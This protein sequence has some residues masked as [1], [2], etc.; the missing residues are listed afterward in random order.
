MTIDTTTPAS[1]E[2]IEETLKDLKHEFHSLKISENEND[3][4]GNGSFGNVYSAYWGRTQVAVKSVKE[5]AKRDLILVEASIM[6]R[7]RHPNI[8]EFWGIYEP[9]PTEIYLVMEKLECSMDVKLKE[10]RQL[11]DKKRKEAEFNTLQDRIKW[12]ADIALAFVYL[13]GQDPK[14]VH[15]D[16][17]PNNVLIGINNIAKVADFGISRNQRIDPS[18][19][20]PTMVPKC[21]NF[22]YKPPEAYLKNFSSQTSYDVYSYAMTIYEMLFLLRP[23]E[24]AIYCDDRNLK[25]WTVGGIRPPLDKVILGKEEDDRFKN[26]IKKCWAQKIEDRPEFSEILKLIREWPE[27]QA[28]TTPLEQANDSGV[29]SVPVE[30]H[31]STASI[32]ADGQPQNML[33]E[34]NPD[35][36]VMES[37]TSAVISS[38]PSPQS[39]TSSLVS[40]SAAAVTTNHETLLNLLTQECKDEKDD[41]GSLGVLSQK[42]DAKKKLE[43][44]YAGQLIEM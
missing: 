44:D 33:G 24:E 14:L 10:A 36:P 25:Q 22:L 34:N 42:I 30:R 17:K 37:S 43:W 3:I 20:Q 5:T 27:M 38:Q 26:L 35:P 21:G 2:T 15:K 8:V 12:M 31:P 16:L 1:E 7:L 32:G 28:A 18:A 19:T 13:H 4:L 11:K 40:L 29:S 9:N 39:S 41:D 23:F 6:S